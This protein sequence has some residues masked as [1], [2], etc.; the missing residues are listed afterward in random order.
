MK[1]YYL[2]LLATLI[3]GVFAIN[4]ASSKPT[5]TLE[6]FKQPFTETAFRQAQA[7]NKLILIDVYATWCSTCKRQQ[8]VLEEYFSEFNDSE[9]IVFE[10][11]YDNQKDWVTYFQAPRQSTLVLFR[12]EEQLWFSVAQTRKRTIFA[13]LA[14]HDARAIQ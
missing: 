11:D 13:E 3:A 10:V 5:P 1:K 12:G 14:K 8:K 4:A 2:I 9:V 7:D 6:Q